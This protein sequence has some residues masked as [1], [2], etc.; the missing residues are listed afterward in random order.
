MYPR[1]GWYYPEYRKIH[2]IVDIAIDTMALKQTSFYEY[3][4]GK[5]TYNYIDKCS[6]Y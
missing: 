1:K 2:T 4:R 5:G 6:A 3:N